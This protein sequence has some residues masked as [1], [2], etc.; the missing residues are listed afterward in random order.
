MKAGKNDHEIALEN[1]EA[2]FK[3]NKGIHALR[4]AYYPRQGAPGWMWWWCG[5]HRLW[6]DLVGV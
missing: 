2:F 1:P 5:G 3:H 4:Q 6:E